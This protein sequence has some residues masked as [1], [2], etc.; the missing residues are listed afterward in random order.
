MYIFDEVVSPLARF[1]MEFLNDSRTCIFLQDT[2]QFEAGGKQYGPFK[3]GV[4]VDLPNWVLDSFIIQGIV[5]LAP[6]D[7]Y[8]SVR[9]IQNFFNQERGQPRKLHGPLPSKFMYIALAQ[10]V[11]RLKGD[12]TSLDPRTYEEI[13]K[14]QKVARFLRDTRLSKILRVADAG[15][16]QDMA[17]RMTVEEKWLCDELALLLSKWKSAVLNELDEHEEAP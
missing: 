16:T 15:I 10:K 4:Q 1:R 6:E 9:R 8:D 12:K 3:S 5:E 13:D 11:R 2:P 14:I 17:R 7:A